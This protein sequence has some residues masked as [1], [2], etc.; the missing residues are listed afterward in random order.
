MS[1][2]KLDLAKTMSDFM[3]LNID[4]FE[5]KAKKLFELKHSL[6][7]RGHG[8]EKYMQY[9]FE[10]FYGYKVKLNGRT[11]Q[12]DDGID[13][14]WIKKV[15]GKNQYLV[16]QCKKHC[17]KDI[18]YDDVS[19]FYGKVVDIS[20]EYK[21]AI[22]IY[23]ITTTKFTAKAKKFLKEKW[24]YAIDFEKISQ[25]QD[26]YPLNLFKEELRT[27]EWDKEVDR[28]FEKEQILLDLDDNII[29]T[30][31][32]KDIEVL[33]LLKQVRRDLSNNNQI[34][35][36]NI[37]RNDTLELLSRKRPHNLSELKEVTHDLPK[38]ERNKI[39]RYWEY[40][41]NRLKEV[42]SEQLDIKHDSVLQKILNFVR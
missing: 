39:N 5:Q 28:C 27:K 36:W 11:N 14:K 25:A 12:Q 37:A 6:D 41:V 30:V 9:Y 31:E 4:D 17:V 10:K 16:V 38:R 21:G 18:S 7:S 32:A 40:F 23:Y 22:H 1:I 20:N 26:K 2:N 42:S 8:F 35:L 34:R 24:I 13:L 15:D 33:Q 29:N 3:F 19:K